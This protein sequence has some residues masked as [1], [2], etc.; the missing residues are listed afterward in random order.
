M[1]SPPDAGMRLLGYA[2]SKQNRVQAHHSK[3]ELHEAIVPVH[4]HI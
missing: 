1:R 4:R 3:L 2:A